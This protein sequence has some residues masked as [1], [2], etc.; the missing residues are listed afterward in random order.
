MSCCD[1]R[2]QQLNS[3][4]SKIV[5]QFEN[6]LMWLYLL[7]L[8][9]K[10]GTVPSFCAKYG[11]LKLYLYSKRRLIW[12]PAVAAFGFGFWALVARRMTPIITKMRPPSNGEA[13]F[14]F[15]A[16]PP[17]CQ[18]PFQSVSLTYGQRKMNVSLVDKNQSNQSRDLFIQLIFV[19][20]VD[21]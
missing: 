3:L 6:D 21:W 5:V 10:K 2:V 7:P 20:D 8:Y 19:L 13:I 9:S 15:K 12:L 11:G 17:T 4:F 1:I 18:K 14:A 16:Q